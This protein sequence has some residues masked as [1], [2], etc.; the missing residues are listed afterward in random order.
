MNLIDI[1]N[2][3][4]LGDHGV[5]SLLSIRIFHVISLIL[6][7]WVYRVYKKEREE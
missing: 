6:L 1:I 7:A 2:Y 3:Q 4:P 5:N